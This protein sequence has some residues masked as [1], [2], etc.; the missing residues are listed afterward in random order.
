[1]LEFEV[2][3]HAESSIGVLILLA[4]GLGLSMAQ[5]SLLGYFALYGR[6]VVGLSGVEAGRLLALAQAGQFLVNRSWDHWSLLSRTDFNPSPQNG[7][8]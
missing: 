6:E 4:C 1:M 3:D 2:L 8:D 7:P 5:S